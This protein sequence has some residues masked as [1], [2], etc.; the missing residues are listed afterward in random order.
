MT[1]TL[2]PVKHTNWVLSAWNSTLDRNDVP[3][4]WLYGQDH[5]WATSNLVFSPGVQI[6]PLLR[7]LLW[8]PTMWHKKVDQLDDIKK[9]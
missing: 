6:Y 9:I 8:S 1:D 4:A 7:L 5:L 2:A 3:L